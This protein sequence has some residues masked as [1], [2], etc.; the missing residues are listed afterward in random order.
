[1]RD[2]IQFVLLF[3]KKR[4]R[5]DPDDGFVI[6]ES[7]TSGVRASTDFSLR[8][9]DAS[10]VFFNRNPRFISTCSASASTVSVRTELPHNLN[11]VIKSIL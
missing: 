6:Q 9:I 5:K 3:Q 4:K 11:V 8:T 1:M 2:Y 10:D 7:S